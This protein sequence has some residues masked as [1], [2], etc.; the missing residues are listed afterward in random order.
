MTNQSRFVTIHFQEPE[1]AATPPPGYCI[2][3]IKGGQI[4]ETL[5]LKGKTFFV[6]GRLANCDLIMEHPSLSRHHAVI[7]YRGDESADK[8]FQLFDLGSTHGS[9]HNKQRCFASRYYPLKVGHTLKFGGSSRLFILQGPEEDMEA[10]SDLS[11]T[12]LQNKAREKKAEEEARKAAAEAQR[13]EEGAKA[14]E[15]EEKR[16]IS[17]GFAEDATEEGEEGEQHPDMA[18]N[19]FSRVD[20]ENE[21][22]YLNDPKKTLRGWF[23]REGFSQPEYQCD[24]VGYAQFKCR[25]ELPIDS[26]DGRAVVA[27]ATVKG[28]KKE[29]VVQC[30]LEAC[31]LLDRQGLLRQTQHEV[32]KQKRMKDL[33]ENDFYDSDDDEFLDRTGSI[34]RKRQLRMKMAGKTEKKEV[35]T[36]DTLKTKLATVEDDIIKAQKE[37]ASL[38]SNGAKNEASADDDLD[39]FMANLKQGNTTDKMTLMKVKRRIHDLSQEKLRLEKLVSIATP[40]D[41]PS[42]KAQE[43][44]GTDQTSDDKKKKLSGIM[45]GK[46]NAGLSS[47]RTISATVK[48]PVAMP[49]PINLPP[50]ADIYSKPDQEKAEEVEPPKDDITPVD[51]TLEDEARSEKVDKFNRANFPDQKPEEEEEEETPK[52]RQRVRKRRRQDHVVKSQDDDED[53]DE[54]EENVEYNASDPKYAMWMPPEGQSGDGRT[55]LNDKLGY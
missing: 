16:G 2:E 26:A 46:R 20:T 23:E 21:S 48:V 15:A 54:K 17:W 47:R 50:E 55:S 7:Q 12:E 42:L 8:G 39:S 36:F 25:V 40:T 35:E 4:V 9:Y 3:V 10:E 32:R 22:L 27:E 53:V 45:I 24:E 44:G 5:P 37:L 14:R 31:R 41:L 29:A 34:E 49:M 11:M 6:I 52:P 13:E 18:Q 51:Q 43:D 33:E 19:P 28:K 38:K 30:A 1:W